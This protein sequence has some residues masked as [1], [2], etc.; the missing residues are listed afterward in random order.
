MKNRISKDISVNV[1]SIFVFNK[2]EYNNLDWEDEKE[3]MYKEKMFDVVKVDFISDDCVYVYCFEDENEMLLFA[4]HEKQVQNNSSETADGKT[5][6]KWT[7]IIP[8]YFF[9]KQL[10][11]FSVPEIPFYLGLHY[12]TDFNSFI[13]EIPSPPP[14]SV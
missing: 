2:T 12:K 9:Q 8:D 6:G 5:N 11:Y 14:K 10:I 1:S 13:S 3:F 7:K 4:F